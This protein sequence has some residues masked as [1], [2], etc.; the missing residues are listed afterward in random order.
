M[1]KK[2]FWAKKGSIKK[3]KWGICVSY[4]LKD[5]EHILSLFIFECQLSYIRVLL[6]VELSL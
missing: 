6:Q 1:I 5:I 2:S 3:N 4:K